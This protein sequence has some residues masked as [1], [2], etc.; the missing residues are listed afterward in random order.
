MAY[1]S[2]LKWRTMLLRVMHGTRIRPLDL[3]MN[4]CVRSMLVPMRFDEIH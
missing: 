3:G 1:A 4:F 2:F